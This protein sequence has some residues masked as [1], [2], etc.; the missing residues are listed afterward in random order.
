[1]DTS[2]GITQPPVAP[3]VR[4][5]IQ[6]TNETKIQTQSS[7]DRIATSLSLAHQRKSKNKQTKNNQT[8]KPQQ[9]LTLY[10]AD[11]HHHC[12]NL[13]KAEAKTKKEFK[14]EAWK[15]ETSNTVSL[16]KIMKMQRNIAQMKEQARNIEA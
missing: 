11:T 8:K 5:L 4:C 3:C 12:T 10:E 1:M 6:T 14:L 15:K 9:I 2:P 16:K 13:R 7:A